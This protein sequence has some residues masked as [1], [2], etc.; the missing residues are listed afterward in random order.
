MKSKGANVVRKSGFKE[1]TGQLLL[2]SYLDLLVNG[3]GWTFKEIHTGEGRIDVLC[4]Y[5]QQREIVELKIWYGESRY[6]KGLEQ[7][8]KYLDSEGLDTGYLV[9]FDKRKKKRYISSKH[10]IH[11]KTIYKWVV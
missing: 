4:I 9:I 10:I 8:S 5:E 3:K 1:S 2:I 6:D 11:K 7:L